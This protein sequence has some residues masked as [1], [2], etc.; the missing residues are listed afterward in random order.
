MRREVLLI[1]GGRV[2][3]HTAKNLPAE[4]YRV[5]IVERDSQKCE[6][7]TAHDVAQVIEGDATDGG[8]LARAD[9]ENA[10]IVA[11]LTNDTDV[12]KTVC[13]TIHEENPDARKIVRISHDGEEELSHLAFIDNVVYP[14]AAGAKVTADFITGR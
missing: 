12:N 6:N 11:G 5:T 8:T 10:D 13:E 7:L 1:G 4:R 14:A 3:R 2:G 9:P